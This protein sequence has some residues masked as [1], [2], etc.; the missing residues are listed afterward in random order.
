M[1]AK[2]MSEPQIDSGGPEGIKLAHIVRSD[3][4]DDELLFL[5]QLGLRWV[6]LRHGDRDPGVETLGAVQARF[7]RYGLRI[8][9]AGHASSRSLKIQLGQP[10]RE[11]DLEAYCTFLRSL[12]QLGIR[13]SGYD[14]HPGNTFTTAH[15]QRRGYDA[16]SRYVAR[17]FDLDTFRNEVEENRFDR[18][19][20]AAEMWDH[21]AA[22]VEAVLPVAEQADVRLALHPD[23]PPLARM[24]GV[25][26]L[27]THAEG[28]RRAD[29]IAGGSRHWGLR[30]CVGT[31]AEGGG[32][33]GQ[34]VWEMLREWGGQGRIYGLHFRNVSAPLPRFVETFPDDGY[35]DMLCVMRTLHE[36]GYTGAI[37]PDHI[38]QLAGDDGF[39]R[40]GLAYCIA[41]MRTWLRLV[42]GEA[43]IGA[44]GVG[45]G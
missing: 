22:F 3:V 18:T 30:F 14:F 5:Q 20:S 45:G 15:A 1:E 17:E 13:V 37:V 29:E 42:K 40:A 24:N 25:A 23:D 35:V 9:G 32:E 26:K 41:C 38:P 21:Y 33:M 8:Y 39:R 27:F 2:A 36:V 44:S 7:A 31:W 4:R 12:G 11:A 34:D 19:Y 28:Y 16:Q 43:E 6:L 10:G